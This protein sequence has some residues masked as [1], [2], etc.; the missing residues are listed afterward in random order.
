MEGTQDAPVNNVR[1][2]G[3]TFRHAAPTFMADQAVGSGGDYA[4]FLGGTIHLNG[5][6]GCTVDHNLFDGVGGNG[7]WLTDYNR[8]VCSLLSAPPPPLLTR[9]SLVNGLHQAR[10]SVAGA[11]SFRCL[12]V[13]VIDERVWIAHLPSAI[14]PIACDPIACT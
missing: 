14:R 3:I 10:C 12:K 1:I 6:T 11:H 8:H 9:L 4:V 13:L 5:T 2:T 7:I